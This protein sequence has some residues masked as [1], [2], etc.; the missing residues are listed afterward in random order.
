MKQ[1][2]IN[3]GFTHSDRASDY[4]PAMD[5]YRPGAVQT[6]LTVGPVAVATLGSHAVGEDALTVAQV[7]MVAET[8]FS[9]M[10]RPFA[11]PGRFEQDVKKAIED[12]LA[13]LRDAAG[14]AF[15]G[16][17]LMQVGDTVSVDGITV[18]CLGVG[19]AQVPQAATFDP[20]PGANPGTISDAR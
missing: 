15:E 18:A 11:A 20:A 4:I 17:H 1:M 9:A 13:P 6:V 7:A 10:N 5:G 8:C 16:I 19:W 12:A 2:L 14:P 3:L